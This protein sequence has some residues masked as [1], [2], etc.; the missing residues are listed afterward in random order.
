MQLSQHFFLRE[1]LT[2]QTAARMGRELV[3]PP[4]VIDN[5]RRLCGVLLEP[6]RV[7]LGRPIVVTSG[8]RPD[9]LNVAI[10]GSPT[11]NHMH[12]LAA[13]IEVVGM[14][15]PTFARWVEVN[16][17]MQAWP[18]DQCILEFPPN[19]WVHL[20]ISAGKP[21]NQFMTARSVAGK[22]VYVPGIHA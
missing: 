16:A 7:L 2:S 19:G 4:E 15:P 10:G 3:P 22:T 14:A 11:S 21:R 8:W 18:I 12:G 9:W 6:I 13:D 20:G 1:F 17:P 5:L